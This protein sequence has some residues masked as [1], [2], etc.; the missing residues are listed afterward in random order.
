MAS[1]NYPT[2]IRGLKA[3]GYD[4]YLCYEFCH[5]ALDE[6]HRLQGLD[7]VDHHTRLA[8]RYLRDLLVLEGVY[9][10]RAE[11]AMR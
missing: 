7:F 2:F 6:R 3:T 10:G 11:P 9:T 5:Q 8:V 1:V 4:G